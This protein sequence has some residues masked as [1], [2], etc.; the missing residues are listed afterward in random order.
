MVRLFDT[1]LLDELEGLSERYALLSQRIEALLDEAAAYDRP[2]YG[3]RSSQRDARFSSGAGLAGTQKAQARPTARPFSML[4]ARG[5][6]WSSVR[7]AGSTTGE[8]WSFAMSAKPP[9]IVASVCSPLSSF[10]CGLYSPGNSWTG[11]RDRCECCLLG[12]LPFSF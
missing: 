5:A 4:P 3:G 1:G 10:A 8:L 9:T 11:W 7:T 12:V 6:T 2:V